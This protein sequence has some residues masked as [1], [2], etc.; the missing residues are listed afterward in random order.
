M[1]LLLLAVLRGT[2]QSYSFLNYTTDDGLPTSQIYQ[3]LTDQRGYVWFTSDAGI[4][5]FEMGRIRVLSKRDNLPD[6]TVFSLHP[7]GT[8][9]LL[10]TCYNNRLF[11]L[12]VRRGAVSAINHKFYDLF[13]RSQY[14]IFQTHAVGDSIF[15]NT[16]HGLFYTSARGN[17]SA[18]RRPVSPGA[19]IEITLQQDVALL[20]SDNQVGKS[21]ILGFGT[22][23][24]VRVLVHFAQGSHWFS[25]SKAGKRIFHYNFRAYYAK[26]LKA[27]LLLFA[28]QLL[29]F[30]EDGRL[31]KKVFLSDVLSVFI[32]NGGDF[33]VGTRNNGVFVFR[34]GDLSRA[35]ENLLPSCGVS[36][37][38][39]DLEG[40]LWVSTINKGI[41]YFPSKT[42]KQFNNPSFGKEILRLDCALD[43]LFVLGSGGEVM[44]LASDAQAGLRVDAYRNY[45]DPQITY[46][47]AY[48]G[49]IYIVG[50]SG[51]ILTSGDLQRDLQRKKYGPEVR[52]LVIGENDSLWMLDYSGLSKI[53][54]HFDHNIGTGVN[55][56]NAYGLAV[57]R[58]GGLVLGTASG[59][60]KYKDSQLKT[61]AP[62]N[63]ILRN[64][65]DYVFI[66]KRGRYWL[67]INGI[68][69]GIL[70]N[71]D[72][73]LIPLN[74]DGI[75]AKVTSVVEQDSVYWVGTKNGL[76]CLSL[77][78][79]EGEI[80]DHRFDFFSKNDGL[81]SNEIREMLAFDG[82]LVIATNKGLCYAAFN[83][84]ARPRVSPPI[85]LSLSDSAGLT[86][87]QGV[88][89]FG[90]EVEKV[91]LR[92]SQ[93]SYR[94][95]QNPAYYYKF[96]GARDSAIERSPAIVLENL[97]Y[98]SYTVWVK[99]YP[100]RFFGSASA[101]MSFKIEKPIWLRGWFMALCGAVLF[102]LI[103]LFIRLRVTRMRRTDHEKMKIQKLLNE[104][105][106]SS[107]QAQMNPH[108]I[109]NAINS[110]QQY[111]L[112]RQTGAAYDYL[113][114]FSKLIRLVLE[115]SRSNY[116]SLSK[117][118]ELLELYV[119]LEQVRSERGFD[120][121]VVVDPQLDTNA[122]TI[123]IMIIQ[124]HIE[125]AI[126]HGIAHLNNRRG[127]IVV[128]IRED[129]EQLIISIKDNGVGREA[130]G[131][132]TPGSR[133]GYQSLSTKI[134][135]ERLQLFESTLH[136]M[137]LYDEKG[138]AAGTEV[139]IKLTTAD[140]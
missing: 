19:N 60:L 54:G 29:V 53:A 55:A 5:K 104:Y 42:F 9:A 64:R 69:L 50:R 130:A 66:D 135:E 71:N 46:L 72:V 137:D 87:S 37:L 92:I 24:S 36:S 2:S 100:D 106:M 116:T 134:N 118:M 16:N 127:S 7:T 49:N 67:S 25:T 65:I 122:V 3:V 39:N 22:P 13:V 138:A 84:L 121:S 34:H 99:N 56:I 6:N 40:G 136:V 76:F 27:V 83:D 140:E 59:L 74:E 85:Y 31:E 139:M 30:H 107:L 111:I 61:L 129:N 47:K 101:E 44:R 63:M 133:R 26:Q 38:C 1:V 28:D 128:S 98:G 112:T 10:G 70:T 110:I 57:D 32:D 109:F 75:N 131:K 80:R 45:H 120:Y 41:F 123:P 52:N 124:P 68:G 88:A 93:P 90:S 115:M 81:I 77:F 78:E 117:E 15:V 73:Y 108:F 82:Q 21:N 35:P 125:N 4:G 132:Y 96:V 95:F 14:L 114:R 62:Q 105:K 86:W 102:V 43:H 91:V 20:N 48:K 89:T 103:L 33:W 79:R 17:D 58:D 51:C 11:E 94:T 126:W 23:D 113:A 97:K 119:E 12:N 18:R 8:G